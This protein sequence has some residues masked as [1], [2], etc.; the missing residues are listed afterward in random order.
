VLAILE[1]YERPFVP[2]ASH[3]HPVTAFQNT[4]FLKPAS[5]LHD[6][7]LPT[8]HGST[9]TFAGH[10]SHYQIFKTMRATFFTLVF[11][12][13]FCLIGQSQNCLPN[14]ITFTT[15]TQ[16]DNFSASYPGCTV[17]EGN[18]KI[19]G[20]NISNLNGLSGLTAVKSILIEQNPVLTNLNGLGNL[21]TVE[22]DIAVRDNASLTSLS[23][24]GG[25]ISVPIVYIGNN[26]ALPNLTGLDNLASTTWAFTVENNAA[27]TS[28]AGLQSF[29]V[30]KGGGGFWIRS[31]PSL[32]GL[33]GLENL[34]SVSSF[35]VEKNPQLTNLTGLSNLAFAGSLSI[36][37][38]S[39]LTSLAE[40]GTLSKV[41]FLSI[42]SNPLLANLNGLEKIDSLDGLYIS[43]NASIADLNGLDNLKIVRGD[44][45]IYLNAALTS[46]NGLGKLN[47]AGSLSIG[48][49]DAL[50]DLT[51]LSEL[52]SVGAAGAFNIS[53]NDAL[54][55][56]NGLE[57]LTV[58]DSS[59]YISDNFALTSLNGLN[60]LTKVM[61]DLIIRNNGALTSL[62]S[63]ENITSISGR[64]EIYGNTA[65]TSL[66]GLEQISSLITLYISD[67][68]ALTSLS[69]L[70]SLETVRAYLDI[71]NNDALTSLDGLEKLTAVGVSWPGEGQLNIFDNAVLTN[72]NGLK[73]VTT[74]ANG[75][76][77]IHNNPL[78]SDCA[79][80]VVCHQLLDGLGSIGASNNAPGCNNTSEIEAQCATTPVVVEIQTDDNNDCSS[81]TPVPDLQVQ[82]KGS[83]QMT[84]KPTG[85][86]GVVE[87][88]YLESGP[89]TLV[90]PEVNEQNWNISQ[91]I[92]TL[93][94]A[95]GGDSFH[96][97]LCLSPITQCPELTAT[98]G[99]PSNF[100]GCLVNSEIQIS[101][102]NTGTVLAEGVRLAAVMPPVFE[103]LNAAPLVSFQNGDT[104]FFEMGDLKPFEKASA[105]LSVKTKCDTF[106]FGQTL[107]WQTFA[108]MDNPCPKT[109]I[110]FSEIKLS[111]E[112]VGDTIVRLG[113]KNIGDA[114]TQGWHA[115][116]IIRNDEILYD[117]GFNLA[118]QQSLSF[119]FPADGATWRIEATK[120]D[121][122]TPTAVAL[123][124][125]GGLTPGYINAFWLDE[126]PV[127]Y[128]F[129][130]RQ[131]IGSYDPNQKTAVP[132]G[133]GWQG[134][135]ESNQPLQ[136][137]I[138]FQN[139]GTDTAFRVLLRDALPP[140]LDINTF[141]P[142][143]SS[144]PCTWELRSNN[145]EVLFSPIAL[146][147]SNV[148]EP[149]SHGYF[150]FS[151]DQTPNLP[152]GTS[153]YN[154]ASII[155]DFNPP[156]WTNTVFHTIGKL[157]VRVD[158]AQPHLNLWRVWGNPLRDAAIFRTEAFVAGEKRFELYDAAGRLVRSEQFSG[159]EF[160]FQ[161]DLLPAGLYFFRIGDAQG[162]MFTGKI[163]VAE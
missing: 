8:P 54:T 144:H 121:D 30:A 109:P 47:T 35:Y 130:C 112:C 153:F 126:G 105:T 99:L 102:Q 85:A 50:V 14:G 86:N 13:L 93:T 110:A 131:V 88:G 117:N 20:A 48:D 45:S 129:D 22:Q 96:V 9:E 19:S 11:S 114:P 64:L 70:A 97:F 158:E 141:R 132:T 79:I 38:N 120:F 78:L 74:L 59:F 160:E 113:L 82:L 34:D 95:D 140:Q 63:L 87:F 51:G 71:I 143:A 49:N 37:D 162:R 148:N 29:S 66:N 135:I 16:I 119:D 5:C 149:A 138:D 68:S 122:G 81:G 36:D 6:L 133:V 44:C 17:I 115:Y 31:N 90:L 69:G 18:V 84:I 77:Q 107:C 151:I 43:N 103:L 134:V 100:R 40:I 145:L 104:L 65:L 111:A 83:V 101:A 106:L 92:Q 62:S 157:S 32:I 137:T 24:L 2:N 163:V 33:N 75:S 91:S 118:A 27:L 61:G 123:E 80:F 155:F 58:T 52:S 136:Y 3:S 72:L 124:N 152:D 67:N 60:N 56:L 125:C 161:R 21:T 55:S 42:R 156:I 142:I 146:P 15:Q 94:A 154:N 127:D 116:N 147:D 98:L 25:L 1:K 128:D 4:T 39:S 41:Y 12:F 89:F 139:T 23:G 26:N 53:G 28:L 76:M 108:A 7:L 159:Q 46:L 73:Q 150:T 57:N 10:L